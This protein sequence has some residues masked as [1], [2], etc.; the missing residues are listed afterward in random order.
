MPPRPLPLA[1][2]ALIGLAIAIAGAAVPPPEASAALNAAWAVALDAAARDAV[3]A[4][5][6]PGGVLLVG[7]GS[8]VVYRKAFGSRAVRPS[9]EPATLDTIYDVASLTKVV[10]TAPAVLALWE[11]GRIDLDAPID[12]YLK[13]FR[14]PGFA[15]VTVRRV[16]LHSAGFAD[17]PPASAMS[18]GPAAAMLAIAGAGLQF[19]PGTAFQYSDTGF[20]VLAELVHR[21]SGQ[22]LDQFTRARFWAPLGMK[23]TAFLPP[24]AWLCRLAR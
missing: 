1:R 17:L 9:A 14:R 13:E 16:L 18:R 11:Q 23:Q 24:A 3:A 22:P 15:E 10:A 12:T 8:R 20:I 19:A 21:V 2:A 5:D 4:G 6:L 7:E